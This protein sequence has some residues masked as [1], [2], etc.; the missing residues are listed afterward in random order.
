MPRITSIKPLPETQLDEAKAREIF[1]KAVAFA[2]YNGFN[3]SHAVAYSIISVW[4][5]YMKANYPAEFYAA[6]ISNSD[7]LQ[8]V[9]AVED[10][11][12]QGIKVEMPDINRSDAKR[13][14]PLTDTTILAPLCAIKGV[15]EKAA[16]LIAGAR[17]GVVDDNGLTMFETREEKVRGTVTFNNRVARRATFVSEADFIGRVYKRIVNVRVIGALARSGALPW[18]MPETPEE[19]ARG[20]MELLGA[21]YREVPT[22]EASE[23]MNWDT[24]T[25]DSLGKV[26]ANAS[27]M[28]FERKVS[29][30]LPFYGAGPRLMLIFDKPSWREGKNNSFDSSESYDVIR[31]LLKTTLDMNKRDFYVTSLFK[32]EQPPLGWDTIAEESAKMLAQEMDVLKPPVTIAF[33][34]APIE[35]IS[36]GSRVNESHGKIVLRTGRAVVLSKSV[37]SM[38][39]DHPTALLHPETSGELMAVVE[40]LKK[41]Y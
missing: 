10:A 18:A 19:L 21:I 2:G 8:T 26:I 7:D 24:F 13:F 5:A 32:M 11:Q 6:H 9:M 17:N 31:R 3:K 15:G 27:E 37:Y 29:V 23:V 40:A 16:E 22:V 34:K 12:K 35:F 28:A 14:L 1:A 25:E 20:R 33:G 38:T 30:V 4:C 36:P 41:I 39:K